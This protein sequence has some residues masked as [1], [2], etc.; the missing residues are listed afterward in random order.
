MGE[1]Q[2][3]LLPR[4]QEESDFCHEATCRVQST[5]YSGHLHLVLRLFLI[6]AK[7]SR[8][9]GGMDCVIREENICARVDLSGKVSARR[10]SHALGLRSQ[11]PM[12][13]RT[14]T[15]GTSSAAVYEQNISFFTVL[16]A[17]HIAC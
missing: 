2:T 8:G 4:G 13:R 11:Y 12:A 5:T 15:I 9:K 14:L 1:H 3:P 17:F 7:L 16:R 10:Q 6:A